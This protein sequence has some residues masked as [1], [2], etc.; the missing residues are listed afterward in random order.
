MI[1]RIWKK[2]QNFPVQVRASFWFL[3]CSFLQKGIST[4][5]TPIFTRLLT[6]AEYGQYNVFDSWLKIVTIF[7]SLHLYS[8]VYVQGLVK[9]SEHRKEYSSSLQG[10]TLT[11][12]AG[13]TVIYLLFRDFWNA[14]FRLTT[15]QMLAMLVMIWATAAF[16]FWAN[17]QRVE[18]RYVRLVTA[19]L[20]VSI[21]KPTVGILFVLRAEDKVTA[22]I[23]GLMLVELIGYTG[24]FIVQMWRGRVFY[25]G[26]FW[27]H[28][29]LFN[30]PL[31]PHYLS[32]TVL[33][34]ADRIMI[35]DMVGPSE[36]GIYALAYQI[37]LIMMLFNTALSQTMSPWIYQ[38]IKDRRAEDISRVAY[39][40]M[41]MIAFVNLG[42]IAIAPEAVA[43]FAPKTYH[44]AI[45]VIPP[46]TMSVLYLFSYDIFAKFEF[47]YEKTKF[48]MLASSFGAILNVVLNYI[49]IKIYGYYAAG[50]TTL[51]CYIIY[52]F[53]HYFFMRKI[54]REEM[55]GVY[56]YDSRILLFIY[57]IFMGAGFLLMMT[58]NHPAVR[59]GIIAV[60][61]AALII[62]RKAVAG[63]VK[64]MAS[65]RK[66]KKKS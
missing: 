6:T 63:L 21:A 48:I 7:V 20:I 53:A 18:Y 24:F 16:N 58:Y 61:F 4:I 25:S 13:W 29:L 41:G 40:A 62:K 52:A 47:Y 65:L 30:L 28:A 15:V 66:A 14:R 43:I 3:I 8:G 44:E 55:G 1:K 22:R 51:F 60:T 32:Q 19:T 42:V 26:K 50:Y 34:S 35:K 9:N 31:I 64:Q 57:G 12:T 45:W 33:N 5:S 56:V 23:L 46:V 49:F 2:Y 38:K 37:S 54:C 11:L 10:L 59:Y 17:E 39:L 36:A 27:K